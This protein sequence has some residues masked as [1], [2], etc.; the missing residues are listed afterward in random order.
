MN[1]GLPA[2]RLPLVA[3]DHSPRQAKIK[4]SSEFEHRRACHEQEDFALRL[5]SV[6]QDHSP[7]S[8]LFGEAL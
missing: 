5:L 6:A 1:F 4:L 7:R 8:G 3:L 2:P